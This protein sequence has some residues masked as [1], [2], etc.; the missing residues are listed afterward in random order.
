MESRINPARVSP[1]S[2]FPTAR[3]MAGQSVVA[4]ASGRTAV[5]DAR[6]GA[7]PADGANG[8]GP[9]NVCRT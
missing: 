3:V 1:M 8:Q 2:T 7:D 9:G 6:Q 5:D 4:A